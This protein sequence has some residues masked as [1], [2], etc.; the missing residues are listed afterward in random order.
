DIRMFLMNGK[1]LVVE[2]KYAA[3]RRINP[4]GDFRSNMSAGGRPAKA[5]ITDRELRLAAAIGPRLVADGLVLV[6][7]DIVGDRSVEINTTSPGGLN[8]ASKLEGV[9]FGH[10]VIDAIER[11][12]R[13]RQQ[14][15]D[16][17]TNRQLA[18]MD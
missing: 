18:S 6:G 3:V 9:T 17:L 14:Y 4:P 5:K 15:G 13:Y 1:P 10:A 16:A 8:V 7:I 11:K 12:L 2:G